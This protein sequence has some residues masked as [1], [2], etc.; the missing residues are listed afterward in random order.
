M[1]YMK[2]LLEDKVYVQVWLNEAP[3][4]LNFLRGYRYGDKMR[5]ATEYYTDIALV[6]DS[7]IPALEQAFRELNV[8]YPSQDWA[9]EY[10]QRRNRSLSVGDVVVIG[11][12]AWA[13]DSFGWTRVTMSYEDCVR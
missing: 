3:D 5:L 11:E 13:C 9:Q 8:D 7:A 2:R 10:R 1:S 12:Q 6:S 4:G